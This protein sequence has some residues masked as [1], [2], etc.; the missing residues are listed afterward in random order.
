MAMIGNFDSMTPRVFHRQEFLYNKFKALNE[1][2]F[3]FKS[4]WK[5]KAPTKA[6]LFPYRGHA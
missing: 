5:S 1:L 3:P 2:E 6:C 4:I